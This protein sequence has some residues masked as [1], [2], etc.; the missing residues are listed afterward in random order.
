MTEATAPKTTRP[1]RA[2]TAAKATPAPAKKAAPAAA[3]TPV[4]ETTS[5]VLTLVN[6]GDTVNWR[7]WVAPEGSGCTGKFYTSQDVTEVAV[8]LTVSPT[9]A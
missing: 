2:R 4:T 1:S 6:D 7:R 8:R 5:T 9:E 3:K